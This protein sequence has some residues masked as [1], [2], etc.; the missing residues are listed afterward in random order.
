MSDIWVIADTH[1]NHS[2][3]ILYE[4]RPF[5]DKDEMNEAIIT[6]WNSVVKP[7]D[8]VY[9]LGDVAFGGRGVLDGLLPRLNGYKI[10]R[11]GNHDLRHSV[12]RWRGYFDEVYDDDIWLDW[13]CLSHYPLDTVT[14]DKLIHLNLIKG[15]VHGHV[16]ANIGHL[17]QTKYKCVSVEVTD[18]KPVHIDELKKH[19]GV[20]L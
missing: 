15:N 9:H 18:Y 13:L 2:N 12:N 16:H 3:I 1:L 19:F 20:Q 7:G 11:R 6:G 8:T 14:M 5:G 17:D 4:N 10:L